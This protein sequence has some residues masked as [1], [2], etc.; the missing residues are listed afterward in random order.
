MV[1]AVVILVAVAALQGIYNLL[2]EA[3]HEFDLVDPLE[4]LS[5]SSETSETANEPFEPRRAA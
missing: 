1:I 2:K 5:E 4:K 3:H